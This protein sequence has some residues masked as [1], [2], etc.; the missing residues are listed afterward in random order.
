MLLFS[1]IYL[2]KLSVHVP[3]KPLHF[4]CEK[5]VLAFLFVFWKIV[6][7]VYYVLRCES[8]VIKWCKVQL[9]HGA[10]LLRNDAKCSFLKVQICC[11]L[12]QKIL[13]KL[14]QKV[15]SLIPFVT[16]FVIKML[17]FQ[18]KNVTL[19]HNNILSHFVTIW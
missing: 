14:L 2:P 10:N 1:P 17:L 5:Y 18:Q 19:L 13:H 11:I 7:S 4:L 8:S 16:C 3:L 9:F 15:A 6:L 12:L